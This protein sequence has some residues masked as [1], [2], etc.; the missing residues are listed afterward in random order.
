MISYTI[1][2]YLPKKLPKLIHVVFRQKT[3]TCAEDAKFTKD[4]IHRELRSTFVSNELLVEEIV[5]PVPL[6]F[7]LIRTIHQLWPSGNDLEEKLYEDPVVQHVPIL[8]L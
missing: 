4:V 7:L 2:I 3:L 6:A 5:P 8:I 1:Y